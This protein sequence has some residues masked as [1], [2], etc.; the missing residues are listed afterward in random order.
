MIGKGTVASED[1]RLTGR[2]Q[3]HSDSVTFSFF[4]QEKPVISRCKILVSTENSLVNSGRYQ[5]IFSLLGPAAVLGLLAGMI[6]WSSRQSSTQPPNQNK[7]A[8]VQ[9]SAPKEAEPV[10]SSQ[11]DIAKLPPGGA[12]PDWSSEAGEFLLVEKNGRTVLELPSDPML[13][14]RLAWSKLITSRGTIRATMFGE[15]S[16]RNSPRFSLG[17]ASKTNF[18]LRIVPLEKAVKIVGAKEAV[19]A[20]ASWEWDSTRP[21]SLELRLLPPDSDDSQKGSTLEGRVWQSGDTPPDQA[22]VSA[23]LGGE[24]SFVRALAGVAPYALKPVSIE[25]LEVFAE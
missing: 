9:K 25:K 15:R 11:I 6:V 21:V 18:W 3:K 14:G 4:R 24:L 10:R 5:W 17:V 13:E 19:L 23:R 8:A 7:R 20:S 1:I 2:L 22:L 16:R 12:L